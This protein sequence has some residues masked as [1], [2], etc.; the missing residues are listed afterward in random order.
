MSETGKNQTVACRLCPQHCRLKSGQTGR[1]HVRG[2]REGEVVS[3][4]Y[5]ELAAWH[6]D[7]IEKKPLFH[8]YPGSQIFSVGG[9]GCN[10]SCNFCQNYEIS[11]TH[12]VGKKVSPV[13]LAEMARNSLGICF[14]YSE[15]SVWFEMIRDTVPLVK[16][17]DGKVV[18]VSNGMIEMEF[19]E[20]LIPWID[21]VNIDIKGF[22]E[23]FYRDYC[24]GKLAWV[25]ET[26]QRLIGRV[27]LEITTLIIPGV[28]D[29]PLEIR[30]LAK[31]LEKLGSPI[32]WH[33]SRYFPAYRSN[34]PP[35][36]PQALSILGEIA[37]E[38]LPYVYLGNTVG[39]NTTF[40]PECGKSVIYRNKEIQNLLNKGK[41]PTCDKLI[42]GV[43]M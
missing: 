14:T 18:L 1:C 40:C 6:L 31:W 23:E 24:G 43:G 27:H 13:E 38:F 41:C 16:D 11:Q 2:N 17:R 3:L 28:N 8:F 20:Q 26:V 7:P 33:L 36:N 4:T 9:Y 39:G 42:F 29:D 34:I 25:L 30:N 32:A 15:P 35:T 12:Q 21:A 5:G 10:L 19:L 37:K 22:R